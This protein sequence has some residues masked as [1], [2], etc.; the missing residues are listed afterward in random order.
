MIYLGKNLLGKN[1]DDLIRPAFL[2][3]LLTTFECDFKD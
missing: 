2:W 3:D 1:D